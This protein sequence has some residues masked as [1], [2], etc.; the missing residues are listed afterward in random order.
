MKL[1]EAM[2]LIKSVTYKPGWK[3]IAGFDPQWAAVRM[4]WHTVVPDAGAPEQMTP[5]V[6]QTLLSMAEVGGMTP[7]LLTKWIFGMVLDAERHEA[8]EFFRV[9]GVQP[10]DPHPEMRPQRLEGMKVE[11]K[12]NIPQGGEHGSA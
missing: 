11:V 9:G 4:Y 2:K 7:E 8:K 10:Y 1:D 12:F 3:L 6:H 5:V